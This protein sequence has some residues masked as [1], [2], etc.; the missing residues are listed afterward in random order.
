MSMFSRDLKAEWPLG[1]SVPNTVRAQL[2]CE[3][4]QNPI[5]TW[6]TESTNEDYSTHRDDGL[7]ISSEGFKLN[8]ETYCT[9]LQTSVDTFYDAKKTLQK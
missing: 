4:L 7:P 8:L 2:Q 3:R 1:W 6:D 5:A 9:Q